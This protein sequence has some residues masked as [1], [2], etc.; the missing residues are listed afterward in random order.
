LAS[1]VQK[2]SLNSLKCSRPPRL[3]Q[4]LQVV[5]A[6]LQLYLCC[7][8]HADAVYNVVGLP[9]DLH[10]AGQLAQGNRHHFQW[11]ALSL[12]KARPVGGDPGS[13]QG[14]KGSDRGIDGVINLIQAGKAEKVI[15]QVKVGT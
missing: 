15:V 10:D 2:R 7:C 4:A 5:K 12:V 11:W 9:E 8:G 14:K 3:Q 13:K 1:P 6:L